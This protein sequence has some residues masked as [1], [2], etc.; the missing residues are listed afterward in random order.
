M[1]AWNKIET[2]DSSW[3]LTSIPVTLPYYLVIERRIHLLLRWISKAGE[4]SMSKQT[5][6]SVKCTVVH[7]CGRFLGIKYHARSRGH[8]AFLGKRSDG[9][10]TDAWGKRLLWASPKNVWCCWKPFNCRYPTA[11]KLR[12]RWRCCNVLFKQF[13]SFCFYNSSVF[14]SVLVHWRSCGRW[15]SSELYLLNSLL[16]WSLLFYSFLIMELLTENMGFYS[17]DLQVYIS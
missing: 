9:R 8:Q 4:I 6:F 1:F 3:L 17:Y 11:L 13:F 7:L 5:D 2:E 15:V 10:Q 16:S 14:C 12:S